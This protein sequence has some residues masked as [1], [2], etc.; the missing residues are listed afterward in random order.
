MPLKTVLFS[1]FK[2]LTK[3]EVTPSKFPKAFPASTIG[4]YIKEKPLA[5][6][7]LCP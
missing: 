7:Y 4:S 2:F 3:R 6:I 5:K 1:A